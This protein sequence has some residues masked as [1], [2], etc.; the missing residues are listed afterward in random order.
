[1]EIVNE[2]SSIK[3]EM[4]SNAQRHIMQQPE[5]HIP[6]TTNPTNVYHHHHHQQQHH[7]ENQQQQQLDSLLHNPEIVP[8]QM[9]N[10]N[11]MSTVPVPLQ[12]LSNVAD[13]KYEISSEFYSTTTTAM[14][15]TSPT[16]A[17]KKRK[18]DDLPPALPMFRSPSTVATVVAAVDKRPIYE[19]NCNDHALVPDNYTTTFDCSL[20]WQTQT[21]TLSAANS[22][23]IGKWWT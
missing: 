23:A 19:I 11:T 16:I 6:Q 17:R 21:S 1:M 13:R 7:L 12:V 5:A 22:S 8:K 2:Y 3:N 14:T 18:P 9:T 20:S 10:T 4:I 15:S